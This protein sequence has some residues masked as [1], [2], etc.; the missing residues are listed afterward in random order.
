MFFVVDKVFLN[1]GFFCFFSKHSVNK[2]FVSKTS[3]FLKWLFLLSVFFF[4][5]FLEYNTSGF[6]LKR[7]FSFKIGVDF[8]KKK[9]SF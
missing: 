4:Q 2:K 9:L 1:Q 5:K 6:L 3:F 8:V 7:R